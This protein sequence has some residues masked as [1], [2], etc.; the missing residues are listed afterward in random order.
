SHTTD[1][2]QEVWDA[3]TGP[4]GRIG[5]SMVLADNDT[6]VIMFGGRDNEITRRHIPRTYEVNIDLLST[7]TI[8]TYD[9]RAPSYPLPPNPLGPPPCPK[10]TRSRG[11]LEFVSYDEKSVLQCQYNTLNNLTEGNGT[12][13][14]SLDVTV[15]LYYNDVWGYDLNCTR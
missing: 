4:G 11:S 12:E 7:N 1:A 6:R 2:W 10:V 5:H 8:S 14:C 3:T 13:T 15:G 9:C